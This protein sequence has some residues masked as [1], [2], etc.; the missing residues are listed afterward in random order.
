MSEV[1]EPIWKA[2]KK[3]G[4]ERVRGPLPE[5]VRGSGFYSKLKVECK[6]R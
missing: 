1:Q 4:A 2:K 5:R 3:K 6:E